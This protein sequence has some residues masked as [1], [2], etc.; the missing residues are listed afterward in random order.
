MV[1]S[2]KQKIT[3]FDKKYCISCGK[4]FSAWLK[5][6]LCPSC[7]IDLWKK[8]NRYKTEKKAEFLQNHD[9]N[10]ISPKLLVMA[11]DQP[12]P[13]MLLKSS[14]ETKNRGYHYG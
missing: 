13:A 7:K 9:Y 14:R 10:F 8:K 6:R 2:N 12:K 3:V 4:Q 1:S 5:G 11:D